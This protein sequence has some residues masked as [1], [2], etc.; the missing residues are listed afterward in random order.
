MRIASP[1]A[2]ALLAAVALFTL[3]LAGC[4]DPGEGKAKAV[5]KE[6]E[7]VKGDEAAKAGEGAPQAAAFKVPDGA[8][9]FDAAKSKV[10]FVGAKVTGKH[11]GGFKSFTGY[12][13][14]EGN[15][16]KGAGVSID[17]ASVFS[18]AEK[19]TGHL[20]SPDFFD[21]AKHPK[22]TF[23]STSLAEGGDGGP[24]HQMTGN[25]TLHGVTKSVTFPVTF[26]MSPEAAQMTADFAINRKD[27]EITYP[28]KPDDLIADNVNIKLDVTAPR[29]P[30]K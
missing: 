16:P 11:P 4:P 13:A 8:V 19:L 28:G 5:V 30:A 1:T 14:L 9:K 17:M 6:A 2:P 29:E 15:M 23:V 3:P 26:K 22:A 12:I 25:L 21:V 20:K 24:T 7:P 27:F 18:D 10:E